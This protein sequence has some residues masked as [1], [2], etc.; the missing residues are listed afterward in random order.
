MENDKYRVCN[1]CVGRFYGGI[2]ETF[3]EAQEECDFISYH[4]GSNLFK[5]GLTCDKEKSYDLDIP[6]FVPK[7]R[8]LCH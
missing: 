5:A 3:E 1:F 8:S 2:Y 4:T 7:K 6:K